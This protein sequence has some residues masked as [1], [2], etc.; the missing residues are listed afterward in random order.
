MSVRVFRAFC[1]D[2]MGGSSDSVKECTVEDCQCHPYRMGK[3]PA[4]KAKFQ[5]ASAERMKDLLEIRRNASKSIS[6]DDVIQRAV[7]R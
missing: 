1:L 4:V 6:G 3:N 7:L 5:G 2:C